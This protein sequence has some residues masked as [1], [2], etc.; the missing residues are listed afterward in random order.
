MKKYKNTVTY[1]SNYC[2]H[3]LEEIL[4]NYGNAGYKLVSTLMADNQYDVPTMYLFFT[5]EIE[6]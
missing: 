6:E 1:I 4:I 3:A 5:K 2:A